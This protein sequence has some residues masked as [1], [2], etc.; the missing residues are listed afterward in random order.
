MNTPLDK[1]AI[2]KGMIFAWTGSCVRPIIDVTEDA[3]IVDDTAR[4]LY[5]ED[6]GDGVAVMRSRPVG[7][8]RT[9]AVPKSVMDPGEIE[10]PYGSKWYSWYGTPEQY[11]QTTCLI[12]QTQRLSVRSSAKILLGDI[13]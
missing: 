7:P 13:Q 2:G 5:F 6:R 11:T 12:V 9:Y 1:S 4:E 10:M 3:Y 8:L